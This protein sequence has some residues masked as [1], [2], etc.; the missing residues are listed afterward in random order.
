MLFEPHSRSG[1]QDLHFCWAGIHTRQGCPAAQTVLG[2]LRAYCSSR[3]DEC[4][5]FCMWDAVVRAIL[6][7]LSARRYLLWRPEWGLLVLADR[8][9]GAV[10]PLC[11]ASVKKWEVLTQTHPMRKLKRSWTVRSYLR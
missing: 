4:Q 2:S 8:A 9:K 1:N 6:N 10:S 5:L 3:S 7:S 11:V